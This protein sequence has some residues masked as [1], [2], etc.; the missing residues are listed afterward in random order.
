MLPLLRAIRFVIRW[1]GITAVVVA[2]VWLAS[3]HEHARAKGTYVPL[4]NVILCVVVAAIG[5]LLCKRYWRTATCP[6]IGGIA[7]VFG[8]AERFAGPY[9]GVIGMLV[10][11]LVMLLP[12][13]SKPRKAEAR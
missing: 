7:G 2:L 8:I 6:I 11:L 13:G 5:A 10:G 3:H 1:V 9:G 4:P 12:W